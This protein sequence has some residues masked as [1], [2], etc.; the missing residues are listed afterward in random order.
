MKERIKMRMN[1]NGQGDALKWL[2]IFASAGGVYTDNC[3]TQ[4]Q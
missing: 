2:I 4:N 3:F 1:A